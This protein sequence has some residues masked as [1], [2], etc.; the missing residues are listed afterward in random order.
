MPAPCYLGLDVAKATVELASEPAGVQG[1]FATDAAG[2][3]A[4]V[5]TVQ[6]AGAITLAVVEA[7]GGY[8]APVAAA[9]A[10]AGVP[11][12]VVNPRQV[13]HFA[14]AVGQLAKTDRLDARLLARFAARVQPEPRPLPDAA[15]AALEELLARRRQLLEMLHAERQRLPRARG[16]E[17]RRHLRA[18][19]RWLEHSLLDT[20][21][22]L[23]RTIQASPLWRVQEELLRSVPGVGPQLARTL[24][25]LVPE[26][27]QLDRH[28]IA[29]LVGVAPVA[30]DSGTQRGRRTC[31]GGRRAVRPVLYMAALTASRYH[32]RL[33][34][35]YQRLRAA[36]KP[37]KVALTAVARKLLVLLNAVLR[38]QRRWEPAHA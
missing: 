15:T 3:A 35:F 38:D 23:E 25:G 36:G 10:T 33:R 20:D 14:Q 13:R 28:A 22:T 2:L 34:V 8:E 29:A 11:V 16:R 21:A 24:L 9:L 1:R 5:A 17:V 12:A 27:G 18:H 32:P 19:I 6:G 4:L 31:W 7:T 26:L 37:A 30:R